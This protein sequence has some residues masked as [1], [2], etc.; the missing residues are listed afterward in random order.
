MEEEIGPF[1]QREFS[2]SL[3]RH[4]HH[5]DHFKR[6]LRRGREREGEGGRGREGT[7]VG[8]RGGMER[9]GRVRNE[10]RRERWRERGL[11]RKGE[12]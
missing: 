5:L 2:L 12:R 11:E 6:V 3:S 8:V 7:G 10:G 1:S 9:D 4:K